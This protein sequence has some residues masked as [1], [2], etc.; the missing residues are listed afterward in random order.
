MTAS[1]EGVSS[2]IGIT[3]EDVS[4]Q[5]FECLMDVLY[6]G[7]D[8]ITK[9]NA[10]DILRMS[11]YLQIKFLEDHCVG[12]LCKNLIV[13]T[14]LES[15]QFAQKY[16]LEDFAEVCYKMSV[17]KI[18]ITAQQEELLALPKSMVL[19]LLSLQTQ[20]SADDICK[21][22]FCWVEAKQDTRA[23]H[24]IEFLP[25][26]CFPLLSSQYLCE[27]VVYFNHPFREVLFDKINDALTYNMKG[28]QNSD[29]TVR[30]RILARQPLFLNAKEV[31]SRVVMIGGYEEADKPLNR[32]IV[33][34]PAD[35]F[36]YRYS[37]ASLP[38]DTGLDFASCSWNNEVYVSGGSQLPKFFAVYKPGDN[39]WEVLP[40][41]PGNGREK[42]AMAANNSNIFIFGGLEKIPKS[43]KGEK[44]VSSSILKY[45]V[46]SKEWSVFGQLPL[47]VQEATAAVLGHRI[48]LFGGVGGSRENTD[49]VQCVDT[50]SGF[51]YQA[52]RLPSPMSGARAVS[53]GGHIYVATPTGGIL[54]MWE[55]FS[56]AD[57]IEKE[58]VKDT[59]GLVTLRF[60]EK[61]HLT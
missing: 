24:L 32:V 53:N 26:V 10:K 54:R 5:A 9:E 45:C 41:L 50:L 43:K 20:L 14:C 21:T 16:D 34:N 31:Q 17:D 59:L 58:K 57:E 33:F 44:V 40:S 39:E 2:V 6:R 30:K 56:V 37:L 60:E 19:I 4:Q 52:G 7:T 11:V 29:A 13:E 55:K 48:Y 15:W 46:K 47:G 3:H 51:V 8:V 38:E 12:F 61:R 42:H 35:Y 27:L 49:M 25:F 23:V 28:V 18:K 22:V 36:Y 1:R